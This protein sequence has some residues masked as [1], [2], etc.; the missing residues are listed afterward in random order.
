MARR[1]FGFPGQP[2]CDLFESDLLDV[3]DGPVESLT[4][5]VRE[6]L[7]EVFGVECGLS[8][9]AWGNA[10]AA[11][12]SRPIADWEEAR[13]RRASMSCSFR[14]TAPSAAS[15]AISQSCLMR[16]RWPLLLCTNPIAAGSYRSRDL[17]DRL[18]PVSGRDSA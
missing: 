13:F 5:F 3:A 16:Y 17:H 8:F 1:V 14:Y 15:T 2:E 7:S 4:V 12:L 11:C 10:G 9:R 6:G 18:L